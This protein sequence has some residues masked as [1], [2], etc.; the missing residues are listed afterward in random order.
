[1]ITR[2]E[3]LTKIAAECAT[4]DE[5]NSIAVHSECLRDNQ[6]E[7]YPGFS[8]EEWLAERKR[9]INKPSWEN[10]PEWAQYLAM[11]KNGDWVFYESRQLSPDYCE[12][13]I[14]DGHDVDHDIYELASRAI[15]VPAG[16]DWKET[17]EHR[18]W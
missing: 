7:G 18:H 13:Y 16:Y 4:W 12:W 3:L 11:D 10:S 2:K 9:L 14:E 5:A 15:F 17:L 8:K 6:Q 1:M